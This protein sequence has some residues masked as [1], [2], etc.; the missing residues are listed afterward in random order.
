MSKSFR[1]GG[2][3]TRHLGQ[4]LAVVFFIEHVVKDVVKFVQNLE[5]VRGLHVYLLS[6]LATLLDLTRE[7]KVSPLLKKGFLHALTSF[8]YLCLFACPVV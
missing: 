7:S 4:V 8:L 1:T 6:L 5:G 2:G 3:R